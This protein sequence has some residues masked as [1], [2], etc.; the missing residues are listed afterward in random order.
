VL[1]FLYL[2]DI[3]RNTADMSLINHHTFYE[4]ASK[5]SF[6]I[7]SALFIFLTAATFLLRTGKGKILG[8]I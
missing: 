4:R 6:L 1:N 2:I 5:I 3:K 7:K 8:E